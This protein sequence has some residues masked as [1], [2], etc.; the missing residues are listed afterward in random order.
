MSRRNNLF[1]GATVTEPL[2]VDRY[3]ALFKEAS[4]T[5]NFDVEFARYLETKLLSARPI[6]AT[7]LRSKITK[8]ARIYGPH[9]ID[10]FARQGESVSAP[11]CL[12]VVA[13]EVHGNKEGCGQPTVSIFEIVLETLLTTTNVFYILETFFRLRPKTLDDA[14]TLSSELKQTDQQ[15]G[16]HSVWWGSEYISGKAGK[17]GREPPGQLVKSRAVYFIVDVIVVYLNHYHIY[18]TVFHKFLN[19]L[20]AAD[21]RE[22]VGLIPY[23]WAEERGREEALKRM[24][25]QA[26][27]HADKFIPF[28]EPKDLSDA[29]EKH[30]YEYLMSHVKRG[31]K[32]G[33]KETYEF[34]FSSIMELVS[35]ATCLYI[36]YAYN[37]ADPHVVFFVGDTHR[38]LIS[39]LLPKCLGTRV[40]LQDRFSAPTGTSSCLFVR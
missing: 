1:S 18:G 27:S 13:G 31:A 22:D 26:A 2:L 5:G 14:L 11:P 9:H 35:V 12:I 40:K 39:E 24:L 29:Y 16:E 32:T 15:S 19:R 36:I 34:V 38:E 17:T 10:V 33:D 6:N 28:I 21:L 3:K 8:Y 7:D 37:K 20:R 23:H 30:V 4:V 25:Q